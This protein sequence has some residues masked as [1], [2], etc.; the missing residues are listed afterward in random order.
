MKLPLRTLKILFNPFPFICYITAILMIIKDIV[1]IINYDPF[2]D[3]ILLW[4]I[5]AA[6]SYL[7]LTAIFQKKNK[8]FLFLFFIL[9]SCLRI[10]ITIPLTKCDPKFEVLLISFFG[11]VYLFRSE[12]KSEI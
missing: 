12:H 6:I 11:A 8:V 7:T 4:G 10:I 3:P 2:F 5:C 1:Y 9:E